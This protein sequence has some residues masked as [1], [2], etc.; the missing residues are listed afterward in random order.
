MATQIDTREDVK[1]E[2]TR[3]WNVILYNDDVHAFDEVVLQVQKATGKA[4]AEAH[5]ITLE[6]HNKGKSVAFTGDV[7]E[8]QRVAAVLRK[9][10]LLVDVDEG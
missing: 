6:A 3:P 2:A 8:C 9:I 7:A 4:L 10:G 5:R 1:T